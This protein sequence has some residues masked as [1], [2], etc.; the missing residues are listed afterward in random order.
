MTPE[1]LIH[2]A[3]HRRLARHR[4]ALH[5]GRRPR[6]RRQ[7]QHRRGLRLHARHHSASGG[8]HHRPRRPAAHERAR[9]RDHQ[10]SRCRLPALH[11]LGHAARQRHAQPRGRRT[12]IG[13][14]GAGRGHPHQHPQPEAFDLLFRLPAPVRAGEHHRRPA[15]HAGAE[16]RVHGH[17]LRDLRALRHLRRRGAPP[18]R[19]PP[20]HPPLD[21]PHLRR[22]LRRAGRKT[23]L[24]ERQPALPRGTARQN[25]ARPRRDSRTVPSP[26]HAPG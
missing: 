13:A 17:D 9:L 11:G 10:I 16:R 24:T 21:A 2:H 4:R 26:A 23:A 22:R 12:E 20:P 8:R 5:A 18:H 14:Q 6:P 3:D 1:F 25:P 7:G 19:H 15:P